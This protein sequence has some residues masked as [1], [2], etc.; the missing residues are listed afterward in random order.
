MKQTISIILINIL[1]SSCGFYSFT[2]ASIPNDASTISVTYFKTATPHAPSS[3][4]QTITE[5][6]RDLFISETDLNLTSLEA[7]LN[8]IG[9]I[10]KF[11]VSPI[12]IQ[13][14]ETAGKNRLTIAVEVEYNNNLNNKANFKNTFSRYHDF[15]SS[16]NLADVEED[17]IEQITKEILEDIFNK[18][19]V[20]W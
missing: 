18:A 8:F 11:Q 7:D 20:N 4:S 15:D 16:K 17:L 19:F 1:I 9:T 2:G 10:T 13:A 5:G 14:N 3:L 6:L 12:A